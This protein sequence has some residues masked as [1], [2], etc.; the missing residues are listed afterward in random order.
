[1]KLI[2]RFLLIAF[3]AFVCCESEPEP[4]SNVVPST[5]EEP[6]QIEQGRNNKYQRNL[7][8]DLI[9]IFHTSIY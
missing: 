1:M 9:S 4:N 5:A 7:V 3:A 8:D 6:P 2:L